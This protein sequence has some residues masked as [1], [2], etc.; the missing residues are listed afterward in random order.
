MTYV[1]LMHPAQARGNGHVIGDFPTAT[2][3]PN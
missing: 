3:N 2:V 1:I